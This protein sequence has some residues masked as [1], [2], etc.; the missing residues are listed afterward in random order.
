MAPMLQGLHQWLFHVHL[1][2]PEFMDFLL[3]EKSILVEN[4]E[5]RLVLANPLRKGDVVV[6]V[7]FG[8]DKSVS[9]SG[10]CFHGAGK[11]ARLAGVML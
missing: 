4:T 9:V 3:F 1:S 6:Y 5:F 2:L 10:G 11:L 8:F 7:D